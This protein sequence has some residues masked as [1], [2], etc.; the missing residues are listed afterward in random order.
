MLLKA[1]ASLR[2]LRGWR[3]GENEAEDEAEVRRS[4]DGRVDA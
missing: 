1:G 4:T 3:G 2:S